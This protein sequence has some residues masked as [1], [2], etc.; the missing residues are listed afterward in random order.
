MNNVSTPILY[1]LKKPDAITNE[2]TA[3]TCTVTIATIK[4]STNYK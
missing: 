3:M 4:K 2:P 1:T